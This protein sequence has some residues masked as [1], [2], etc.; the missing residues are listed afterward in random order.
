VTEPPDLQEML[1]TEVREPQDAIA[2]RFADWPDARVPRRAAGRH[3][4]PVSGDLLY[5]VESARARCRIALSQFPQAARGD[6]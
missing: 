2:L 4:A 3:L 1:A 6:T 5:V